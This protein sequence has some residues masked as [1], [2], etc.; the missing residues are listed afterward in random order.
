MITIKKPIRVSVALLII[1]LSIFIIIP[2]ENKVEDN[3]MR[4]DLC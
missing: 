1:I 3:P 2:R 4:Q